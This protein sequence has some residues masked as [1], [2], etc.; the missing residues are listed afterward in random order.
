M[1]RKNQRT[2]N[3]GILAVLS[4][5]GLNLG[6]LI[7]KWIYPSL[8]PYIAPRPAQL[9]DEFLAEP[10]EWLKA[11]GYTA[12]MSVLAAGVAVLLGGVVGSLA[13]YKRLWSI[14]RWA[15][16]IWSIPL[17]AIATY[18][19]LVVGYGWAYGLSLAVFLGFYPVEKHVFDYC[20]SRSEGL[21]S[22]CAAFGLSRRQEFRHLRFPGAMRSLGTALAQALPLCFIGET[23]GEYTSAKI[24]DFSI[25][26]GGCLRYAQNYSAYPRL[27]LSIILMMLLVFASGEISK[28]IWDKAFPHNEEREPVQ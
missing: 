13:S 8:S 10:I 16:L 15:Q 12:V 23:M 28:L 17:I 26:L 24:S 25:G 27:W 21:N 19:L 3:W 2:I 22:L 18:L 20:S 7:E 14:D 5:L 1:K 4:I 9:L 6:N 11:M